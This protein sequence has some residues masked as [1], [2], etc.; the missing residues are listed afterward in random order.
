ML[1]NDASMLHQPRLRLRITTFNTSLNETFQ[2][3]FFRKNTRL[4][5]GLAI[6]PLFCFLC[7]LSSSVPA[8]FF[9]GRMSRIPCFLLRFIR[10]C[11]G[12]Q[13][14]KHWTNRFSAK[15]FCTY[16]D[17]PRP[18]LSSKIQTLS[19]SGTSD[20]NYIEPEP[21]GATARRYTVPSV[22]PNASCQSADT[23]RRWT[24]L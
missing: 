21:V 7:V 23:P 20:C 6:M 4:T 5:R 16:S 3:L 1:T 13:N 15:M 18:T 10:R 17:I 11:V 2:Y 14:V 19:L 24:W 8:F 22:N 12:L 9:A